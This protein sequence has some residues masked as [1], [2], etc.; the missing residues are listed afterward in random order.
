MTYRVLAKKL[1]GLGCEF[2]RQGPGSHE[3]WWNP[4]NKHFT[5]VVKGKGDIPKGTLS[6]ILRD[7]DL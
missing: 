4:A 1:R 6:A 3:I 2:V 5:T 7:L